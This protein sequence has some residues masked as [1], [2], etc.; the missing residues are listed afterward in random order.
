MPLMRIYNINLGLFVKDLTLPDSIVYC[1]PHFTRQRCVL[2]TSLY[3]TALCTVQTLLVKTTSKL[4]MRIV[5]LFVTVSF[6]L[7]RIVFLFI[8]TGVLLGGMIQAAFWNS[9]LLF[10]IRY[11]LS[12]DLHLLGL[13]ANLAELCFKAEARRGKRQQS[14]IRRQKTDDVLAKIVREISGRKQK[15]VNSQSI[16]VILPLWLMVYQ[17]ILRLLGYG[18]QSLRTL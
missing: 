12:V 16:M 1:W 9:K 6:I 2:L 18:Q 13:L 3:Q 8:N 10:G 15:K 7:P 14:Y 4:C 11:R 5:M 17:W